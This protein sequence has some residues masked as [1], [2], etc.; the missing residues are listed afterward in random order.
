MTTVK[1]WAARDLS[2][3]DLH[4]FE[5]EP[6]RDSENGCFRNNP[7]STKAPVRLDGDVCWWY[8]EVT[9]ENSPRLVEIN[10]G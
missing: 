8:K 2:F 1:L 5:K 4:L 3:G 7:K 10:I 9:W 6:I